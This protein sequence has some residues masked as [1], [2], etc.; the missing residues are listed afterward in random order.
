[1]SSETP[2]SALL[3]GAQNTL[4]SSISPWSLYEGLAS[5]NIWPSL[6]TNLRVVAIVDKKR[7]SQ[8]QVILCAAGRQT[9]TNTVRAQAPVA[10]CSLGL[11]PHL[12]QRE[13]E[14]EQ[15]RDRE[16]ERKR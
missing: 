11:C 8:Q 15:E 3:K 16:R 7:L 10:C 9:P 6:A 14:I 1:M 12:W 4:R 13:R 2:L 5:Q